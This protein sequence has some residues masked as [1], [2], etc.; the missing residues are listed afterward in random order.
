MTD[1]CRWKR[2]PSDLLKQTGDTNQAGATRNEIPGMPT[3][4]E[5]LFTREEAEAV[6]GLVEGATGKPCPC[7]QGVACPLLPAVP[8][9]PAQRVRAAVALAPSAVSPGDYWPRAGA[10]AVVA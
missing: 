5:V 8:V 7:K 6:Q 2:L 10:A 9:L 1:G 3:G 4:C